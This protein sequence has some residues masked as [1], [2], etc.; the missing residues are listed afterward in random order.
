MGE[1]E[2]SSANLVQGAH[3]W[4]VEFIMASLLLQQTP[5]AV[6][7]PHSGGYLSVRKGGQGVGNAAASLPR[8]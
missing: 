4:R 7:S 8:P 1:N 3:G 6:L 2:G 5:S